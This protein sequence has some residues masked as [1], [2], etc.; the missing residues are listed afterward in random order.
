[1]SVQ[2]LIR[3]HWRFL[4]NQTAADTAA[5]N[6]VAP[7]IVNHGGRSLRNRQHTI[8]NP[9]NPTLPMAE[10]AASTPA[11]SLPRRVPS[12]PDPLFSSR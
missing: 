4:T 1:M 5:H 8:A 11:A 10:P 3:R 9:I 2:I 7:L 6:I 12:I